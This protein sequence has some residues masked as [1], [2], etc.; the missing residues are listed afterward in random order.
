MKLLWLAAAAAALLGPLS[1][2]AQAPAQAPTQAPT[3]APAASKCHLGTLDVPVTM[4]GLRP[5]VPARIEGQDVKMILD[6]GA[7]YSV[8]DGKTAAKLKLKP[9]GQKQLGSLVPTDEE[10]RTVGAG[11]G[12]VIGGL[13]SAQRFE[14]AG[15]SF[16]RAQFLTAGDFGQASGLLGQNMFGHVDN[17]FDFKGG[18]VRLVR[19][20]GCDGVEL[21]YWAQPGSTY[22]MAPLLP[23][24]RRDPHTSIMI[25]INGVQMRAQLDTGADNSFITKAAAARAGVRTTDPGVTPAGY[26]RG[27]D[28]PD[29]KTW[30]AHFADVKIGD[31]EVR[32]TRLSIGDS[33][34]TDFDVLLGADFFLAHHLYVANSQGR[35]YFTYAGG[36]VFRVSQPDQTIVPATPK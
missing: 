26:S 2:Q 21:A 15:M 12:D 34:A 19:P 18:M 27:L 24:E 35:L 3:Q 20:E 10:T 32:N 33:T 1:A 14:F 25:E 28:R 11:G 6:S 22:S 8:L 23:A 13:V 4:V 7:F 29:I 17:E 16:D 9:V 5:L 36:P 30:V 31:E